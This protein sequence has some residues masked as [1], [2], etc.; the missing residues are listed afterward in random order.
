MNFEM[1]T[2]RKKSDGELL[3]ELSERHEQIRKNRFDMANN[4]IKNVKEARRLR[5]GIARILTNL[6]ERNDNGK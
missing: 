5:K 1:N 6:R 2:I 3:R 4:Q